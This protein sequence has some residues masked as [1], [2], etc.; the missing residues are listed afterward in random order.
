M[1]FL[2]V[3][4]TDAKFHQNL[5]TSDAE[6]QTVDT[7]HRTKETAVLNKN[8]VFFTT[9]TYMTLKGKCERADFYFLFFF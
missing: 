4:G 7:L 1:Y 2:Y 5:L 6:V 9:A 3:D 8:P